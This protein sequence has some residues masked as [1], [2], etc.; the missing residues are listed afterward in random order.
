MPI[1]NFI[2]D[3]LSER[4]HVNGPRITIGLINKACVLARN[5]V[6]RCHHFVSCFVLRWPI[7]FKAISNCFIELAVLLL[8]SVDLVKSTL[9]TLERNILLLTKI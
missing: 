4:R 3:C 2:H 1:C 6:I 9:L 8:G 7:V 5:W